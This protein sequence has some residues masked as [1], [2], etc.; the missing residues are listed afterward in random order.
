MPKVI[1]YSA[2]YNHVDKL[3]SVEEEQFMQK[4]MAKNRKRLTVGRFRFLLVF[5]AI[6]AHQPF[7]PPFYHAQGIA[8]SLFW[9]IL[10]TR[11]HRLTLVIILLTGHYLGRQF[12]TMY[13]YYEFLFIFPAPQSFRHWKMAGGANM[14]LDM[15]ERVWKG[16]RGIIYKWVQGLWTR[17][18]A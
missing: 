2:G 9:C 8:I 18:K 12:Y 1:E 11:K 17:I 14:V 3:R 10:W 7:T 13:R 16:F 15:N 4:L 6:H 5:L